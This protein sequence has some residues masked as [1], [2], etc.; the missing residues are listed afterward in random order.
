MPRAC[1][2]AGVEIDAGGGNLALEVPVHPEADLTTGVGAEGHRHALTDAGITESA[3]ASAQGGWPVRAE[4]G[5][6]AVARGEVQVARRVHA[7]A[8]AAF[9]DAGGAAHSGCNAATR[10][11]RRR[12][13]HASSA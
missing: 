9:P 4:A 12:A 1:L 7:Q 3:A 2:G 6:E 10:A 8:A 11:S 5:A 13:A